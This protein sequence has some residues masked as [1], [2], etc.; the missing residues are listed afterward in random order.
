MLCY[1][2]PSLIVNIDLNEGVL[3]NVQVPQ[4]IRNLHQAT[5]GKVSGIR[6]SPQFSLLI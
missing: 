5:H 4:R 3:L 2:V 6:C 1:S